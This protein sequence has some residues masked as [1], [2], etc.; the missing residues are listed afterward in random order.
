MVGDMV[1]GMVGSRGIV[2]VRYSAVI[3]GSGH[4]SPP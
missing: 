1:G 2:C 3:V 4:K